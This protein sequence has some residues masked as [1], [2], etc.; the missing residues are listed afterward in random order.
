MYFVFL[1]KTDPSF[2]PVDI[3]LAHVSPGACR[4]QK[5]QS[6]P[7][8]LEL[9]MGATLWVVGIEPGSS[10]RAGSALSHL[11]I[12]PAS[13]ILFGGLSSVSSATLLLSSTLGQKEPNESLR[14]WSAGHT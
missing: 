11:A 8:E 3:L 14:L 12:S 7:L 10:G 4:G 1:I 9:Q 6:G 13:G 5:R 2:I